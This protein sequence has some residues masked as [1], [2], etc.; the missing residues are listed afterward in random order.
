MKTLHRTYSKLILVCVFS[1]LTITGCKKDFLEVSPQGSLT[2]ALFPKTSADALLATN[3]IYAQTRVWEFHSGGFP[4]LDIISDDTRKGSN[5]GDGGRITLYDNFTFSATA[6]DIFP[7]YAALF[8]AVKSSN[9]VIEYVPEIDMDD[10]L[11]NRYIAE[12]RC[13][14]AFFYFNLVRTFG[15][16]PKV[17]T[18]HP[19]YNLPRSS[20]S[21]IYNDV[22]I[23]DLQ[24]AA[25]QLPE[26]SQYGQSDAGRV[27][28]GTAKA[29]LAKVYLYLGN[30]AQAESYALEVINSSQYSLEANYSD[31]FLPIGQ[32]GVESIFE[33]GALA[34]ETTTNGGNQH[35]NT[36]GVRGN[37]NRGWGFN[38][39]TLDL[40]NNYEE[41]D[42][43]K[44]ASV[45]FLNEVLDGILIEG[46]N[47]TL[48]TTWTDAS[49]T[50]ILEIECYN[51]KVW[52]P[53]T[54]TIEQWGYNIKEMRYADLLLIAAEAMN[55]AGHGA[56]GLQYLNAV[57][58]RAGLEEII[59][60]GQSALRDIIMNERRTELAMESN[61]FYDLVRTGRA[62]S[63]LGPLGFVSGKHELFPIPQNEIDLSGGSLNQN[64]G[65]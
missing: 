50:Q 4:I 13:L 25:A 60:T 14:R 49:H 64:P 30:Y 32:N 18:V 54:Q 29:L 3:A 35:G 31:A 58:T 65:W 52:V 48:D 8:Q 20:A 57:R 33:V 38:R 36:Q 24:Y 41:G 44:D 6:S 17:I 26:K 21:E 59:E 7:W 15:G 9:V 1:G 10:A 34:F 62:A 12:A 23:P 16:V 47:S 61:R 42:I 37:P 2:D 63:V 43:R 56:D 11:R 55:E 5:P 28:R 46:D 45:I 22:I 40:I 51:Q 39:P 19:D 53:G 27:T